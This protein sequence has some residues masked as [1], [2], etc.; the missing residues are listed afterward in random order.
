M[1]LS[2]SALKGKASAIATLVGAV[3]LIAAFAAIF[4]GATYSAWVHQ[5]QLE[6]FDKENFIGGYIVAPWIMGIS[7]WLLSELLGKRL[8]PGD[9]KFAISTAIF[10]LIVA[11]IMFYSNNPFGPGELG[12]GMLMGVV[13][14][15]FWGQFIGFWVSPKIWKGA[16]EE[17]RA[18][19]PK[20]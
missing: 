19:F 18:E 16:M 12:K 9:E 5:S 3:L 11:G 2:F 1:S 8:I 14:N 4:L 17:F 13:F 7:I 20:N 15:N 6:F 10:F